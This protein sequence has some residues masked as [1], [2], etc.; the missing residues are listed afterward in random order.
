MDGFNCLVAAL[1]GSGAVQRA[2][3]PETPM[4]VDTHNNNNNNN[5]PSS[6]ITPAT[7]VTESTYTPHGPRPGHF[8]HS[9]TQTH[10]PHTPHFTCNHPIHLSYYQAGF[11]AFI[12]HPS[13]HQQ[14]QQ[15]HQQHVNRGWHHQQLSTPNSR[16]LLSPLHS[17]PP[18][19]QQLQIKLKPKPKQKKGENNNTKKHTTTKTKKIA[20]INH[21]RKKRRQLPKQSP[22]GAPNTTSNLPLA[23]PAATTNDA[24]S[25]I[26][27]LS[28]LA[29]KTNQREAGLFDKID[30]WPGSRT[31]AVLASRKI[32]TLDLFC[33]VQFHT[34]INSGVHQLVQDANSTGASTRS[35]T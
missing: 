32:E 30:L 34:Y 35:C 18:P 31:W 6:I 3:I 8:A 33:I 23:G 20:L 19:V 25:L 27:K 5:S 2:G 9:Y 28:S 24:T 1:G 15:F 4:A 11:Q 26:N 12:H 17:S 21:D 29:T 16:S 13:A 7:T 14:R 22:A 10:P